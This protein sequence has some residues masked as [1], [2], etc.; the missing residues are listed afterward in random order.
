MTEV[1]GN[2]LLQLVDQAIANSNGGGYSALF[3]LNE[4]VA[5]EE[6]VGY[7]LSV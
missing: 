3:E 2:E 1:N 5:Q 4:L 7:A 6:E